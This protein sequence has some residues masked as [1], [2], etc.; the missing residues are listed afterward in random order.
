MNAQI[1]SEAACWLVEFQTGEADAQARERFAGWLRKSPEHVRAYL[2]LVAFWEDA[3]LYDGSHAIA[4]DSLIAAARNEPD[5]V[6]LAG[7]DSSAA[8]PESIRS[9]TSDHRPW[10]G[11]RLK[12]ALAAAVALLVIAGFLIMSGPAEYATGIGE[13]RTVSLADGSSVELDA[14][15]RIRVEFSAHERRV[16][17]LEGQALFRVAKNAARPF[18]V[19][20]G[21]TRVRD[22]GTQFDVDRNPSKTIV[23][24]IEGLVSV[25]YPYQSL[26]APSP[27]GV[28]LR[29][30]EVGAGQQI[31]VE[32][33][34]I[35]RP[36][37]ANLTTATAWTR[38]ELIFDSTPLPQV[39]A[40]FNRLNARQLV[41]EG[42]QLQKFHLS[43]V[44]PAL[45]PASLPR[46]LQFLRAQPGVQI[47]E[48]DDRIIVT[49]K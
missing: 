24:V 10:R 32:P 29:P 39:A 42:Q 41:I 31:V 36:E 19:V 23:T 22:V 13:Q 3:R 30:I 9:P 16:D 25:S 1:Q 49:E 28:S 43:G 2:E 44:F 18:V 6:S 48:S 5:I 34:M 37:P 14:V 26:A 45:D 12:V 47:I 15:S 8:T 33:H 21:G 7:P 38:N 40:E 17:L 46:L 4:V 27:I 20:S 11:T 35:P